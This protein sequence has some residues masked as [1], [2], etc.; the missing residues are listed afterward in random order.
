[1]PSPEQYPLQVGVK[2]HKEIAN[3]L[4]QIPLL[5]KEPGQASGLLRLLAEAGLTGAALAAAAGAGG[6]DGVDIAAHRHIGPRG[7][8]AGALVRLGGLTGQLRLS[9][10]NRGL[11]G[12]IGFRDSKDR[13]DTGGGIGL[14]GGIFL[15]YVYRT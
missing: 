8:P 5:P 13:G 12:L 1:M 2:P 15:F 11:A 9:A 7:G 10:E 14:G 6:G 3:L 4:Q